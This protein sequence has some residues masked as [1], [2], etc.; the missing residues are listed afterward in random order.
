MVKKKKKKIHHSIKHLFPIRKR[1]LF[2]SVPF[3]FP[4]YLCGEDN[5]HNRGQSFKTDWKFTIKVL[6][7]YLGKK[8]TKISCRRKKLDELFNK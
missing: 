7:R 6:A 3:I 5:I 2:R 4:I 1:N 8:E